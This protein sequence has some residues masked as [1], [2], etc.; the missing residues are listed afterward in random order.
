[1]F[2]A[3]L[4][5]FIRLLDFYRSQKY[6]VRDATQ[7]FL[8]D[9]RR[10]PLEKFLRFRPFILCLIFWTV[11]SC[12]LGFCF[13]V[14]IKCGFLLFGD[15]KSFCKAMKN[16]FLADFFWVI[17]GNCSINFGFE[18]LGYARLVIACYNRSSARPHTLSSNHG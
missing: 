4:G 15:R 16:S 2:F 6:F 12:L 7:L 13:C 14:R 5:D 10:L 3:K 11:K 9:V 17:L 1:V 8:Q 18:T